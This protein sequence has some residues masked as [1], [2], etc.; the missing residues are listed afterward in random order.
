MRYEDILTTV[1]EIISNDKINKVGLT[2]LY[3]LSEINHKQLNEQLF[4]SN[5]DI[6]TAFV[7]TDDLELEVGGI[8][9]KLIKKK[10]EV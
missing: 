2:L 1:S 5:N 8:I 4:Y 9:V 6:Q 7:P 10:I 3:E